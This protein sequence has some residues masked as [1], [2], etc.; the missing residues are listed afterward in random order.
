MRRYVLRDETSE[1]EEG[2]EETQTEEEVKGRYS[3]IRC[4]IWIF[5]IFY[6]LLDIKTDFCYPFK[7][8]NCSL[9]FPLKIMKG[10]E[11]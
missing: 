6:F 7:V 8:L 2:D 3:Q 5:R 9:L 4:H 10:G 11:G 1:G